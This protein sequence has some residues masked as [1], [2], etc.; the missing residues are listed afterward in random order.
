ML[1]LNQQ[2][3]ALV[4]VSSG[5]PATTVVWKKDNSSLIEVNNTDYQHIQTAVNTETATYE[6][7]LISNN[8]ANFVGTFTCIVINVRGSAENSI[9]LNGIIYYNSYALEAVCWH[10]YCV[11]CGMRC[12]IMLID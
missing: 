12:V 1:A 4:C 3:S 8:T 10:Y 7:K 6:N 9:T 11:V 5:G 2:E